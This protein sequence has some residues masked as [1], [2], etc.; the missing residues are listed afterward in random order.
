MLRFAFFLKYK[1]PKTPSGPVNETCHVRQNRVTTFHL[2]K[3]P[4][5][6]TNV[7]VDTVV[8]YAAVFSGVTQRV[9]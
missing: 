4:H 7:A 5:V 1:K 3:F 2:W 8:S 9:V 6:L